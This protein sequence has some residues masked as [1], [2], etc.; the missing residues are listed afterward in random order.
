MTF[1]EFMTAVDANIAEMACGMTHEDFA[2]IMWRDLYED[3]QDPDD[4]T[5]YEALALGDEIFAQFYE[6]FLEA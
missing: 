2:D 6:L 5:V 3:V 1:N 4:P